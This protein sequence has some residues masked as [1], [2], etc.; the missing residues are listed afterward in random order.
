[1]ISEDKA[2]SNPPA[3]IECFG[4]KVAANR[5]LNWWSIGVPLI[6]AVAAFASMP[7][8]GFTQTTALV[9]TVCFLFNALGVGIGLH[10]FFSHHAFKTGKLG[11]ILLALL[12]SAAFQ[13]P[14]DRWV[15]DHRRHHRYADKP[16]DTHS[17]YWRGTRAMPKI[18]GLWFAHMG[19]M[20]E[21]HVSS[22]ARYAPEVTSHSVA[23]WASRHYFSICIG[24]VLFP[25]LVGWLLADIHEAVRCLLWAGFFRVAL[26]HQLTWSV[27]SFGHRYGTKE[28]NSRDESRNNVL[29]TFLLLGEGLHSS[30]HLHPTA[31]VKGSLWKDWNGLILVILK[32]L[33]V[34]WELRRICDLPAP[35]KSKTDQYP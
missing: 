8:L 3:S 23:A 11:T 19:W 21:G 34:V 31:G 17:P 1:M 22:T 30:H 10:R 5:R 16:W 35:P 15:A 14:I 7:Y 2:S 26:L 24:S 12:G 20:L 28:P 18:S 32:K 27:N 9:F 25:A 33:G 13:G 6:G 29:L 4:L